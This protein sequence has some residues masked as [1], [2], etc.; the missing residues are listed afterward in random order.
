M[1]AKIT[2]TNIYHYII[3]KL[4]YKLYYL[5]NNRY[6]KFIRLHIR[7]QIAYRIQWMD[8]NCYFD[9]TC[10]ICGC[11]TTAL[12]M[13]NKPCDKPCYPRM[14]NKYQWRLYKSGSVF[15]DENGTWMKAGILLNGKPLRFIETPNRIV[16]Q[17][18]D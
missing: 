15:K 12:Q 7:E 10:N 17:K 3:G 1:K 2:P 18:I 13:C 4:R 8:K 16:P 9:G 14:M 5:H 6:R 11:E